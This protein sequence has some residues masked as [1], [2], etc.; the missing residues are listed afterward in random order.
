MHVRECFRAKSRPIPGHGDE[1]LGEQPIRCG[2][3]TLRYVYKQRL[4]GAWG[5]PL[6][7]ETGVIKLLQ[8]D[9]FSHVCVLAGETIAH[10]RIHGM[11][12]LISGF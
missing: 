3:A 1:A 7:V 10:V 6:H 12:L 8:K 2:H 9:P 5:L 11:H 4:F